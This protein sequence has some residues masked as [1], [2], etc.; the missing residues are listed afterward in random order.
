[1]TVSWTSY[2]CGAGTPKGFAPLPSEE[3][4]LP[5]RGPLV[6][7]QGSS[8]APAARVSQQ[9]D[10]QQGRWHDEGPVLRVEGMSVLLVRISNVN[11]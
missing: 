10:G 7:K 3:V 1:M 8:T 4:P 11:I 2:P 5:W 6:P 9:H